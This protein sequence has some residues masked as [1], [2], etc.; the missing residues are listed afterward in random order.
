MVFVK[1]AEDLRYL[2]YNRGAERLTGRRR[3]DVLGKNAHMTGLPPEQAAFFEQKDREVLRRG[4]EVDVLEE[5]VQTGGGQRRWLHTKKIPITA[6]TARRSTL[7]GIS[8]DITESWKLAAEAL[9]RAHEELERRVTERTADL[10]EANTALRQQIEQR[11]RTQDALGERRGPG[12]ARRRRW[13]PWAGSP[14]G[15]RTTSTTCCR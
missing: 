12:C 5:P 4:E 15:S 10:V 13:R 7:L 8:L 11:Q 6:P 14:A 1:D 9:E 3:E 2:L